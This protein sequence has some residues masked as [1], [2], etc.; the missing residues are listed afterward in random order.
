LSYHK[1]RR[2]RQLRFRHNTLFLDPWTC[3]LRLRGDDRF[4]ALSRCWA[5][6]L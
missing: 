1:W 3:C 6:C 5:G 2:I 4:V